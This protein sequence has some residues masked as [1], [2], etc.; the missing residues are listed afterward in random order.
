[1]LRF[2]QTLLRGSGDVRSLEDYRKGGKEMSI[3][4]T[5][6]LLATDGS[7]DA[8]LAAQSAVK[9]ARKTGS[10]LHVIHVAE[11]TVSPYYAQILEEARHDAQELLEGELER[12]TE[13]YGGQV[14]NSYVRISHPDE[15]IVTLAQ[16]IDA[17][18]VVVGSRGLSAVRRLLV[19]SVS[20]F[21]V[22]HAPCPVM[23]VRWRPIEFPTKVLLATDGS[24]E[25]QLALHTA[26]DLVAR[27]ESEL[28]LVHVVHVE[29]VLAAATEMESRG[30]QAR[31]E[32]ESLLD[33]QA[34][35]LRDAGGPL[36]QTH[37]RIGRPD[38][39]IVNAAEEL[40]AGVV[41][42]G[43]RGLGGVRRALMGSVS[44]SVV[45]HA[46]CPVLVVRPRE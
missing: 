31:R 34:G 41:V 20:G 15:K 42:L 24:E 46:H 2:T 18:L 33:E 19:G 7:K 17:G 28:H 1:M 25:A 16:E 27:T 43:S 44:D 14:E 37:L 22:G 26:A 12:I 30:E 6:I 9:L 23:V 21:V 10:Q 29:R 39:E 4:P 11:H 3:F 38:D 45:R 5:R 40:E 35:R 32:A 8:N 36:A 13:D